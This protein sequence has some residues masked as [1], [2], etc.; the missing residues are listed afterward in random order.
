MPFKRMFRQLM[1]KLVVCKQSNR[2]RDKLTRDLVNRL[3]MHNYMFMNHGKTQY[4]PIVPKSAD[5]IVD[6]S[7]IRVGEATIEALIGTLT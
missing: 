2:K 4:F 1:L 7:V 3:S 5:A 6:K